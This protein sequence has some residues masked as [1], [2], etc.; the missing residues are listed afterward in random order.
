MAGLR[1]YFYG[2][3]NY[4]AW[5]NDISGS[6]VIVISII[7]FIPMLMVLLDYFSLKGAVIEIKGV[8]I[9][10]GKVDTGTSGSPQMAFELPDNIGIV[11]AI[12]T[13]SSAMNIMKMLNV[14]GA[15]HEI[16]IVN[17][18][19]GNAWWVTRLLVLCAG[20]VRT[21]FPKVLVFFG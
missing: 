8:K 1:I 14:I 15:E 7:S 11:G 10:F 4:G 20:A 6:I 13:D 9:D 19:R 5:Q 16:V 12:I 18:K 21:G 2:G 17:L 3:Q